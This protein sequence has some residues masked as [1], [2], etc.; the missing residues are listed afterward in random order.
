MNPVMWNNLATQQNYK[1]LLDRG[2]K[3]IEPDT[4]DMACGENGT[5]RFPEPKAIY[6]FILSYIKDN[7]ILSNQFKDISIVITAGPTVEAIDPVRFV[8]NNSSGK[9]G[10]EI[11]SE[12]TKRGAK[13]TLIS[14][15]V[16]IPFSK[17]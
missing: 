6:E 8:S 7:Q 2:I 17:L 15:P 14:G 4:G 13:V 9:Q 3:F 10:F 11:A 16:N 12:L 1:T 5:G